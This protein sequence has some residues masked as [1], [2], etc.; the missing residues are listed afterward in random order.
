MSEHVDPSELRRQYDGPPFD[1]EDLA[2]V[3][4]EGLRV[5]AFTKQKLGADFQITV[6]GADAEVKN[7]IFDSGIMEEFVIADLAV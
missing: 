7:A 6:C 5:L 4:E 3:S 2:S 1:V